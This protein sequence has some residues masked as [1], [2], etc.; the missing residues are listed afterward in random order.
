M[1]R[2][3]YDDGYDLSVEELDEYGASG[4]ELVAVVQGAD[5]EDRFGGRG[6]PVAQTLP[7][8]VVLLTSEAP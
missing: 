8:S 7:A 4:W 2:W 3:E 5:G 6:R 1:T